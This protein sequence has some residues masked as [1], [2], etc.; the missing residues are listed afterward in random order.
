[1]DKLTWYENQVKWEYSGKVLAETYGPNPIVRAK[2]AQWIAKTLNK[3]LKGEDI[4]D[5]AV[6]INYEDVKENVNDND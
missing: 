2:R 1:M 6:E 3:W 4:P 5:F